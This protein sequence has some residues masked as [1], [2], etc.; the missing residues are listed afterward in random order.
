[1]FN[2]ELK[3]RFINERNEEVSIGDSYL[4]IQFDK[5]EK[6]EVELNK[7]LCNF[8]VYDIREYYK[9]LNIASIESLTNM[10]SQFS[11]YTNWCMQQNLV[12]DN[13]N[14]FF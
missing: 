8:T 9:M 5:V 13:K 12:N 6:M 3:K 10:N 1:M 4:Q 7:D 2:E 14:N 11:I